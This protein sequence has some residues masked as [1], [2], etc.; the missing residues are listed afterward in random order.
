MNSTQ[1][2]MPTYDKESRRKE[3]RNLKITIEEKT[4]DLPKCIP[5]RI[6]SGS[7]LAI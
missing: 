7:Y 1:K 6:V 3:E 5:R 4:S 2:K